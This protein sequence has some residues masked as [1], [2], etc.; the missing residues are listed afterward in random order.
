MNIDRRLAALGAVSVMA[1]ALGGCAVDPKTGDFI[2]YE[3]GEASKQTLMAQVIEP[4]PTYD[5]LVPETSGEHAADAIDRYR[6][7]A[8]KEPQAEKVRSATSGSGGGGG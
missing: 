8:V 7:D 6:N 4:D 3:F 5:T 2:Q 1:V